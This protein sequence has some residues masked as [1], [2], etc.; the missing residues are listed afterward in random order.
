MIACFREVE[1][2]DQFD[3]KI[4]SKFIDTTEETEKL[5]HDTKTAIRNALSAENILTYRV[6]WNDTS[7]RK[8]YMDKFKQELTDAI[9]RQIDYHLA[10]LINTEQNIP[11]NEKISQVPS[12]SK[13]IL[14][15][16]I[17]EHAVQCKMLNERYCPRQDIL[18]KVTVGFLI[19]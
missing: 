9:K 16:E 1:D 17:L 4:K 5:F 19:C 6:K 11:M 3:A 12:R 2:I 14:Y 18:K 10:G 8:I 15:D 13:D 7:S